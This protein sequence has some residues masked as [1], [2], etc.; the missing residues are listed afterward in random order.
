MAMNERRIGEYR[1]A[2]VSD[3]DGGIPDKLDGA[4][5]G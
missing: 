1:E 2:A 3:Q 5:I 4:L